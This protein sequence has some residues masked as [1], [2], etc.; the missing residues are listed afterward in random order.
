VLW[1]FKNNEAYCY[2]LFGTSDE[3]GGGLPRSAEGGRPEG[4]GMQAPSEAG[5]APPLQ[6]SRQV[7]KETRA[8][9]RDRQ[10]KERRKKRRKRRRV[11]EEG[12]GEERIEGDKERE[13]KKAKKEK[14]EDDRERKKCR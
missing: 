5:A 9:R 13:V 8:P 1:T 10:E 7:G 4:G 6:V 14:K 2:G 12:M 3:V 11:G